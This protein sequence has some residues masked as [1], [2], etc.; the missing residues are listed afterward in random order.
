L[1]NLLDRL[2][3]GGVRDFIDFHI[4]DWHYPTFNV[5]DICVSLG[6]FLLLAGYLKGET[7]R[8]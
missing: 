6:I 2:L 4:G 1:G 5:A 3:L 8:V 7:K